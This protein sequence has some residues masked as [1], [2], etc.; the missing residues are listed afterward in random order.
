ME[1]TVM[2]IE[3]VNCLTV[4]IM[5]LMLVLCVTLRIGLSDA[6]NYTT[7][8]LSAF[9]PQII[10]G[11][12]ISIKNKSLVK[13]Y[14]RWNNLIFKGVFEYNPIM[15]KVYPGQ[16]FHNRVSDYGPRIVFQPV[17]YFILV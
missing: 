1:E 14:S 9:Y 6:F 13:T 5:E 7:S 12:I 15:V 8:K 3:G 10:T 11:Y 16:F 2:V 4:E 17:L